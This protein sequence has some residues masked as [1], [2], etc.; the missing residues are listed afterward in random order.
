M[1]DKK[2]IEPKP[3]SMKNKYEVVGREWARGSHY[4][5]LVQW[6]EHMGMVQLC[7]SDRKEKQFKL[8]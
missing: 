2:R 8:K 5:S 1:S 3:V 7:G 6:Y 4:F